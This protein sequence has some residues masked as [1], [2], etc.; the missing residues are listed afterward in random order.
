MWRQ[1][2]TTKS[3]SQNSLYY[4]VFTFTIENNKNPEIIWVLFSYYDKF[5]QSSVISCSPE[6][7]IIMKNM[8]RVEIREF[9]EKHFPLYSGDIRKVSYIVYE[10]RIEYLINEWYLFS[11]IHL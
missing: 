11:K 6:R 10:D 9:T 7:G 8:N 2:L 1:Y 3:I 5:L 4:K